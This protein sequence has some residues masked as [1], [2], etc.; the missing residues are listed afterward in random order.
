[1]SDGASYAGVSVAKWL[2]L[3]S[4]CLLHITAQENGIPTFGTTVVISSGL[5]GHI[6][7]IPRDTSWLP[8]FSKLKPVGTIY[9]TTLNVPSRNFSE[10][11]PGVTQRSEW[12]AIDYTGKFWIQKPG[13]YRFALN[14]DDGSKLYIDNHVVIDNDGIHPAV[15]ETGERKLKTGIHRIRVSYFQGPRLQVALVLAVAPPGEGWRIFNTDDFKP[16]PDSQYW[17][18]SQPKR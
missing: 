6:Y 1:V 10:G 2:I 11:F 8:R 5:C 16:P 4:L 12:F 13:K 7:E 9:T 3:S 14:S 15:T 17:N 18:T